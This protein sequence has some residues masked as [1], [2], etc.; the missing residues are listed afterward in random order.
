MTDSAM[1]S[2]VEHI[3]LDIAIGNP[4]HIRIRLSRSALNRH[5]DFSETWRN[6]ELN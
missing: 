1:P 4:G 2:Q 5:P 6:C 3:N